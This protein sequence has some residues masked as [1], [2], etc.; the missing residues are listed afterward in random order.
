MRNRSRICSFG[1]HWACLCR[2]QG[3]KSQ[4]ISQGSKFG[5]APVSMQSKVGGRMALEVL[6]FGRVPASV[7]SSLWG[8]VKA[9]TRNS[10]RGSVV[11]GA[12]LRVPGGGAHSVQMTQDFKMYK[13]I[14]LV[15]LLLSP[16]GHAC[17]TACEVKALQTPDSRV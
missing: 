2:G 10:S 16:T 13:I 3:L 12:S 7:R 14:T 4:N 17:N 11:F 15:C 8:G 1:E 5:R 9:Q 6:R